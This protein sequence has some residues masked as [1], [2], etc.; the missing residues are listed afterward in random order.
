MWDY[1]EKVKEHFL[2]PRNVGVIDAPDG[3]GEEGSMACGDALTLMFKLDEEGR[4]ADVKFQTFGCA[5]AIASASILTEMI[6]GMTIEEAEKI[7]NQDIV[8]ELGGLPEQKMHCSVMGQEALEAAIRNYRT[9]ETTKAPE[10]TG[11]VVCNCFGVTEPEIE[12]VVRENDLT[13]VEEVTNYS[14]AGGGCGSCHDDIQEIIDRVQ[15]EMMKATEAPGEKR[16]TNI[17]KIKLIEETIEREIRPALR[18][19]GGDIELIDVAD[20]KVIVSLRGSCAHCPMASFT[21]KSVVQD[22]LRQFV[23]EDLIVEEA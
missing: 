12:R 13:T 21:M 2:N 23:S 8:N 17:E 6:K 19:D 22:R 9:G 4:M 1:T 20:N 18:Q 15:A 16:M 7:T 14:K 3:I 11:R 10:R 5:S